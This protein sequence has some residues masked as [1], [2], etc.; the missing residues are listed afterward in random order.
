MLD[1][2][3]IVDRDS[4]SCAIGEAI[5]GPGGYFGWNFDALDDCL[6]GGWGATPPFALHGDSSAAARAHWNGAAWR[7]ST[8]PLADMYLDSLSSDGAGGLWATGSD[9]SA[10]VRSEPFIWHY[11]G[12]T[13]TKQAGALA[14]DA[15]TRWPSYAFYDLVPAG[16]SGSHPPDTSAG[17]GVTRNLHGRCGLPAVGPAHHARPVDPDRGAARGRLGRPHHHDVALPADGTHRPAGR[18]A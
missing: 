12:A 17:P 9:K 15:E 3:H 14:P 8:G 2:R 16:D 7:D 5:N 6:R 4:F 1:G 10:E 18:V 13:W 11:D